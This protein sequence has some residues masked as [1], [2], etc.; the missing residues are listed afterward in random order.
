MAAVRTDSSLVLATGVTA[1]TQTALANAIKNA[2]SLAGYG[3]SPFD[4]YS[5]GT[6][7]YLIYQLIFDQAKTYGTVYLQ[8]KIT[9][10]LGLSQRLY[11]NWDAVAHTGQNSSTE[12]ASVAVNSVA[13]I[14]FMGLTKSPEMRLV[15]VYQGATAICLGYLRP[16]FK[17]SWWNENVYPYCMIP[18]TLGLFATWYIPSLTPFT[19]SL[20]TSGRIQASFTQAQM[21]SPNPISARR[22]VI[23]GVLFFPW[24]N[25]G[26]AGRSSTD[27][28]IV[29]SGNLLRQDVIQVT[30]G[31]EEYV[32]LGGGTGQPAVRLI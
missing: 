18:N 3:S 27:L 9:S 6:D 31:Q 28:A 32:L 8:I 15:M 14:D 13:Q 7:R 2:F 4:E 5:S 10:N 30:P 23:P 24:S 26:V 29:A 1:I 16:E 12:T 19:G 17:P 11:S 21:V 22:D 20:T 25:E